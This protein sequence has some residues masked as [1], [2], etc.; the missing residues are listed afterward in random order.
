MERAVDAIRVFPP[1]AVGLYG[2]G[3]GLLVLF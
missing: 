1:I 2:L 3:R